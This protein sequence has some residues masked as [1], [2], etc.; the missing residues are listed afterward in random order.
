MIIRSISQSIITLFVISSACL[1]FSFWPLKVGD[2]QSLGTDLYSSYSGCFID[3]LPKWTHNLPCPQLTPSHPA[4]LIP[5]SLCP[6]H[7]WQ[8]THLTKSCQV[9]N[10]RPSLTS[11]YSS[12]HSYHI[13]KSCWF[14]LLSHFSICP[15]FY[16]FLVITWVQAIS[17]QVWITAS[18]LILTAFLLASRSLLLHSSKLFSKQRQMLS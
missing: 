4:L 1:P 6:Y 16:N 10:L 18:G 8:H 13:T 15:F 7:R 11:L 2:L 12:S 3:I 5:L 9:R 17:V 14:Y